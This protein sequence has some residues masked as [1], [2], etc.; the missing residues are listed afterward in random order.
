MKNKELFDQ[1]ENEIQNKLGY[2]GMLLFHYEL[3]GDEIKTITMRKEIEC[4][5]NYHAHIINII[6]KHLDEDDD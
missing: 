3:I 1:L 6:K 4:V 2:Y 5:A